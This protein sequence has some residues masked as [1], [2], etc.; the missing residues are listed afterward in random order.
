MEKDGKGGRRPGKKDTVTWEG[1]TCSGFE[2]F[3]PRR[4]EW[5]YRTLQK[6]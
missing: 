5:N 4:Q 6:P 1:F 2:I 3:I